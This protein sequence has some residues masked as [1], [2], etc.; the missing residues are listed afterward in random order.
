MPTT[1][2]GVMKSASSSSIPLSTSGGT[3]SSTI[4]ARR[5]TGVST[6]SSLSGYSNSHVDTQHMD[7]D[8]VLA[9]TQDVRTFS[10]SLSKLHNTL[11]KKEGLHPPLYK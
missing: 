9:L 2:G 10:D 1:Y 7:Q 6:D 11:H 8:A 5:G 4:S 3:T